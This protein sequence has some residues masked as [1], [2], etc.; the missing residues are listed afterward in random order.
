MGAATVTAR[1]ELLQA[2]IWEAGVVTETAMEGEAGGREE[3]FPKIMSCSGSHPHHS[4]ITTTEF[5]FKWKPFVTRQIWRGGM[6][7]R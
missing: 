3:S 5:K 1:V 4:P 7:S 6:C 2:H